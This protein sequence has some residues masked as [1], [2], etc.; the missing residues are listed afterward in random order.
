MP[1]FKGL[2][3]LSLLFISG[4]F[5][6]CKRDS[7]PKPTAFLALEYPNQEYTLFENKNS[8]F[9]FEKNKNTTIKEVK[10]NSVEI[11][12]PEMKA[13]VYLNYKVVNNNLD[14]L[15]KDA[16]KL[17]YEHFIKADD[18]VEQPYLNPTHKVYGM[19]YTLQGDAA[20]N[21]QFYAT[22]SIHNFMTASL[23]FYVTPNYDSIYPA[24]EYI[25]EDMRVMIE[26]LQWKN[27]SSLTK[28]I[29]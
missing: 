21:V 16:Q 8:N 3:I 10:A 15:L 18:I 9:T 28:S 17:T 4:L 12:Y 7:L 5:F 2:T 22:D 25:A 29:N 26:T 27:Q 20:T 11:H 19:Y 23:Y 24:K 1:Q 6:S 14:N 13:T